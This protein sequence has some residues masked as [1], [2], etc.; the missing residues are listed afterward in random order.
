MLRR[1]RTS[2]SPRRLTLAAILSLAAG[3][4]SCGAAA[5]GDSEV[6]PLQSAYLL[7]SQRGQ[8]HVS[9][10]ASD[11]IHRLQRHFDAVVRHLIM[12]T[13]RS[14]ETALHRLE[15]VTR[16]GDEP[17]QHAWLR[18]LVAQRRLQIERLIAYRHRGLFPRN[19]AHSAD[20]VPI[21]VDRHDTACAV[22][23][24]MRLS[25][26]EEEVASIAR[27]NNLVY[28]PD[29]ASGP[30]VEWILTSGLTQEEAALI[31]PA[32]LPSGEITLAEL[33]EPGASLERD[34]V[35]Y[36]NFSLRAQNYDAENYTGY[37]PLPDAI[38]EVV[39]QLCWPGLLPTEEGPVPNPEWIHVLSGS[40]DYGDEIRPIVRPAGTH[41]LWIGVYP[42]PPGGRIDSVA[43]AAEGLGQRVQLSYDV[44]P[45]REDARIDQ[46]EILSDAHEGGLPF[47]VLV[48]DEADILW[49]TSISST[50]SLLERIQIT[51]ED[52]PR[53]VE[54][55]YRQWIKEF[56]PQS[57]ITV[58]T[59]IFVA[60]D[61][62]VPSLFMDFRVIPEPTSL[63]ILLVGGASFVAF[64]RLRSSS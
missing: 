51:A 3:L 40:G 18:I 44:V 20:A 49:R 61:M 14:I 57:R 10:A 62:Y 27:A 39:P 41:W 38:C 35:R 31:Q 13:D 24:L 12:A 28:V 42:P 1:M 5:E 19:E 37:N 34:G 11:E 29:V 60:N 6:G 2:S 23:H 45:A 9:D 63:A 17:T 30:L 46:V 36:E 53:G 15:E 25:G 56:A 26:W 59:E 43:R 16:E 64:R 8:C 55:G 50:D 4:S 52:L 21:F 7:R 22:G 54:T 58:D 33:L 32:Y 47:T 48:G